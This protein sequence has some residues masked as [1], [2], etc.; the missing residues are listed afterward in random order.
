MKIRALLS[1]V[2]RKLNLPKE[3]AVMMRNKAMTTD[4]MVVAKVESIF[5]KPI[6]PKIATRAAKIADNRA[7]MV[8]FIGLLYQEIENYT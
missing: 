6:F 2:F 3:K 7:Y 5:F 4:R 1:K 8:Q